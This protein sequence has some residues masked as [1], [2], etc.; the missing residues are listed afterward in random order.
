MYGVPSEPSIFLF[1]LIAFVIIGG[2]WRGRR[3]AKTEA[4]PAGVDP[5]DTPDVGSHREDGAQLSG[6]SGDFRIRQIKLLP[7]TAQ[8]QRG[9]AG[10]QERQAV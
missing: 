4:Y 5:I 10:S 8:G 7:V 1:I 3:P 9:R 2:L 6:G